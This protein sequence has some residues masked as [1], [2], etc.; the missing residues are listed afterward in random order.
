[1]VAYGRFG[2]S[3]IAFNKL[4]RCPSFPIHSSFKL[5]RNLLVGVISE[6]LVLGASAGRNQ[7]YYEYVFKRALYWSKITKWNRYN[8]IP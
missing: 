3:S 8:F 7:K 4:E 1:M 2:C 6:S 5:L